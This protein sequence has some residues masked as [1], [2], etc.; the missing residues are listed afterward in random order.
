MT[1]F[2]SL[3]KRQTDEEHSQEGRSRDVS[4]CGNRRIL[5]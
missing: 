4:Q 5:S 2:I 1:R 3:H